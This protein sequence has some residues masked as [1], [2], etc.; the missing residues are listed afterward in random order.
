MLYEFT[1]KGIAIYRRSTITIFLLVL[2]VFLLTLLINQQKRKAAAGKTATGEQYAGGAVCA[3]CHRSIY[4]S[5]TNT[6]HYLTSQPAWEKHIK[7]SFETGKNIFA[8]NDSINVVMEKRD[9]GFY[10]VQYVNGAER[11]R[12]HFDIVVGSGTKGQTYLNWINNRLFQLPITYFTAAQQWSNSPG[13]PGKAVFNR[14]ITSRCLECHSTY[15]QKISDPAIEAEEFSKNRILYG[16]DC[17]K[18]HGAAAKHVKFQSENPKETKARYIVNPATLSRQQNLDLCALCHGGRLSKI[19]P[20]F[21]FKAGDKLSDYFLIDTTS[22]DANNIDVH[23]NQYGL[24]AA[25]ECFRKSD[26]TCSSCHNSHENE[27]R[28]IELFSSR[29]M[30]CH[31]NEHNNFCKMSSSIGSAINKNCID[32]HMPEQPSKAIAVFLQGATTPTSAVMRSHFIKIYPE[33]T[34]K[35]L[36]IINKTKNANKTVISADSKTGR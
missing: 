36:A 7:G 14:P 8:F 10:Q 27:S 23:G 35:V 32:C 25:S 31:N 26:M 3:N 6:A 4:E 15:V 16:V 13:Y 22:K 5:H 17:E 18:C 33:E 12:R 1:M 21:D 28:K 9:T 19:K 2:I 30:T 24:L 11:R 29:C 20:S 34:R